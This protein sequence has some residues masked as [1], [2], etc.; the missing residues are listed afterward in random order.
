MKVKK[1][2]EKNTSRNHLN[3]YCLSTPL[4]EDMCMA[5]RNKREKTKKKHDPCVIWRYFVRAIE[6]MAACRCA[7][8]EIFQGEDSE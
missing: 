7:C 4:P 8:R 6:S 2:E 3:L 5:L 1:K